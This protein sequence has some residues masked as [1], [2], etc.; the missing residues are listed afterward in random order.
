MNIVR[1]PLTLK[2][3]LKSI[4]IEIPSNAK[5]LDLGCG[6]GLATK[7][8][9]DRF[10]KG[11]ITGLDFSEQMVKIYNLN[12]PNAKTVIGNFNDERTF[13]SYPS[14]KPIK[15]HDLYFDLIVSTG[16]LS[17]YGKLNFVVPMIYKKLKKG[18]I[19]I[20]IGVNNNF[21]SK[22]VGVAW[23]YKTAGKKVFITACK[24]SGFLNIQKIVIPLKFFPNS[25][26]RYVVK[27]KK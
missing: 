13:R 10:P 21:F 3:L 25:Y 12:F 20:N 9:E 16:A 11:D 4:P 22:L 27:A 19:L 18:G 5:I 2:A 17:E 8:L 14:N 1:Y 6:T 26:W 23:D 15:F 7:P 24:N